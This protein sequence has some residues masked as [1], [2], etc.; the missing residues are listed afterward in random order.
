MIKEKNL[1][2]KNL[3]QLQGKCDNKG[4]FVQ[5]SRGKGL[6]KLNLEMAPGWGGH[7]QIYFR[8]GLEIIYLGPT[9]A[10]GDGPNDIARSSAALLIAVHSVIVSLLAECPEHFHPDRIPPWLGNYYSNFTN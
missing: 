3:K 6:S 4:L 8:I 10:Q 5:V 2:F 7:M 9:L 1:L